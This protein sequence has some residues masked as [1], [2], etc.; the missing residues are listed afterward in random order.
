MAGKPTFEANAAATL[1][2]HGIAQPS[3]VSGAGGE[4]IR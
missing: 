1:S 3:P 4:P 2:T